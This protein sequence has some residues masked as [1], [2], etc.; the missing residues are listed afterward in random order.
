VKGQTHRLKTLAVLGAAAGLALTSIA[1]SYAQTAPAPMGSWQ[2][3]PGATGTSTI[4]GRVEAPRA[5]QNLNPGN[6]LLVT[7][8]AADTTAQGWAGYDGVEVWAGAKDKGGTKLAS[9]SVGLARPDVAEAIGPTYT[10]SGFSAVIPGSTMS[11]LPAGNTTMYVYLHTPGKGSWYRTVSTTV[12]TPLALAYPNDPVI[13]IAKPQD[14]MNITQKQVTQSYSFTG[15]ALDR[16]PLSSVQNNL[17]QL[18]PGAGQS[19]GA[20]C[21]GCTGNTNN[22]YTSHIG[23]GVSSITAYIDAPPGK[24]DLTA[25]ALFGAPCAGCIQGVSILVSNKG[26][27][28]VQG[29]PQ[30]SVISES[31][32]PQYRFAGWSIT[33]NPAILAQGPHTLFVTATSSITGKQSTAVGHFNIIPFANGSLQKVQGAP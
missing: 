5:G 17:A 14:G 3:G 21:P 30:G 7:G 9:G 13:W 22:W 27:R 29:K 1:P 23:A 2:P 24:G 18:P 11:S 31:Y 16:N 6:S 19:L 12:L 32:G 28:N 15:V 26:S 25:P 8:W 33:I 20:G 4:I 10:N